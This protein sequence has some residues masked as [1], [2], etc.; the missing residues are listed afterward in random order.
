MKVLKLKLNLRL[1]MKDSKPFNIIIILESEAVAGV[2]VNPV[3]V[4]EVVTVI[5][6]V[7]VETVNDVVAEA[8]AVAVMKAVRDVEVEEDVVVTLK[9][10]AVRASRWL[11]LAKGF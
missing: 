11:P 5:V 7:G 4:D 2:V 10:V 1:T 9:L 3:P 6:G 8:V